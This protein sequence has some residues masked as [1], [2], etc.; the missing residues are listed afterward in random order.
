MNQGIPDPTGTGWEDDLLQ[1]SSPL[2]KALVAFGQSQRFAREFRSAYA[3]QF[4]AAEHT[5]ELD[6]INFLDRSVFEHRTRDV[7][8][9]VRS[10]TAERSVLAGTCDGQSRSLRAF[11]QP[12]VVG[13]E[14][15]E[16]RP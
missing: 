2:K 15:D 10:T 1:R 7:G 8:S 5:S 12:P 6:Y 13:D 14:G 9:P 16:R 3:D 4:T 11:E